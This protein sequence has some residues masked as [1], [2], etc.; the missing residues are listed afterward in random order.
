MVSEISAGWQ[1]LP[2]PPTGT[3]TVAFG[4]ATADALVA[5]GT[6]LTVWSLALGSGTWA[7]GQVIRIP[8]QYGS[9]S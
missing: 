8:V 5:N 9:S 3:A 6:V 7:K 1:Q 2:S 4:E